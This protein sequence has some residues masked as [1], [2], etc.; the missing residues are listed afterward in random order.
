MNKNQ[1]QYYFFYLSAIVIIIGGLK[2]ASQAA[3]II[4]LSIFI[5]SVLFPM[6]NSLLKL[7]VPKSLALILVLLFIVVLL[8]GLTY[9]L[10]A[11]LEDFIGNLSFYE[12]RLRTMVIHGLHW[13]DGYGIHLKPKT[14]LEGL[15][16]GALFNVTASTVGNIGVFASK[17][18]LVIIGVAFLR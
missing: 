14:I 18:V 15:N 13:L 6:M 11:S 8:F 7:K 5:A 12:E 17:M 1:I 16:F 4:F 3:V 10:N 9:I 2:M